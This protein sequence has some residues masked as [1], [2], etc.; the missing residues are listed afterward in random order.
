M[1]KRNLNLSS[2]TIHNLIELGKEEKDFS[3]ITS[4]SNEETVSLGDIAGTSGNVRNT[5]GGAH[6]LQSESLSASHQR[7]L[8]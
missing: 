4:G 5:T 8:E 2:Y 1:T 7:D 6:E 3:K